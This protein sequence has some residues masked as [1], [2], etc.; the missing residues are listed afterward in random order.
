MNGV[1]GIRFIVLTLNFGLY[2]GFQVAC[3]EKTA[4]D[5]ARF[6]NMSIRIMCMFWLFTISV[7]YVSFISSVEHIPSAIYTIYG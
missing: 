1:T 7:V 4:V 5:R 3:H 2:L 6:Q